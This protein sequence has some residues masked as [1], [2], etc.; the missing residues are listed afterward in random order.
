M[1]KI[2]R[3]F[4]IVMILMALLGAAVLIQGAQ[5]HV[6]R[7]LTPSMPGGAVRHV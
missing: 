4:L 2:F 6:N 7:P 3:A 1:N 5:R